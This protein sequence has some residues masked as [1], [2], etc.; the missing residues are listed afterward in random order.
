MQQQG[1]SG[2]WEDRKKR[3]IPENWAFQTFKCCRQGSDT[4]GKTELALR[5]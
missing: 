1:P 4:S 3:N 2:L 5:V